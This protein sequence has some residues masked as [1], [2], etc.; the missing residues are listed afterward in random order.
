[1][2]SQHS[3]S[4]RRHRQNETPTNRQPTWGDPLI[5]KKKEDIRIIFQNLNG[6]G[7]TKEDEYR[8]QSFYDL[9]HQTEADI[10]SMAETNTDWRKV[11]KQSTIWEITKEWFEKEAVTA[12]TNQHD[13]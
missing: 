1:M 3:A 10:Y 13:S 12:S 5:N 11:P 2:S 7:N 6:F 4:A 9:M 8:T